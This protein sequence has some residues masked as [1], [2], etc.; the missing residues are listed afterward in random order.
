MRRRTVLMGLFALLLTLGATAVSACGTD[1]RASAALIER[2]LQRPVQSADITFDLTV[3]AE[4]APGLEEPL[5][6]RVTG[7]YRAGG[8]RR[9]PSFD[10]DVAFSGAGQN[11][12]AGLV[13]TGEN[14][15]VTFLGNAY[16]VGEREVARKN[17]ELARAGRD[18]PRGSL[19]DLGIDPRDWVVGA[20][21][22]GGEKVAGVD[23]THLSGRIDVARM[24]ADLGQVKRGASGR[25]H[26]RLSEAERRALAAAVEE[27]RFDAWVARGDETI[28]RLD[29]EVEL[30]APEDRRES[31]R[32]GRGPLGALAAAERAR[33]EFSLELTDVGGDQRI[34]APANPRPLSELGRALEGMGRE[35]A[36][37]GMK[38]AMGPASASLTG[39]TGR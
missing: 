18:R 20:Q 14:A 33:I 28:R 17:R 16:E 39:H 30:R 38:G 1:E 35:G 22:E 13:S 34:Q 29:G 31:P 12:S 25:G 27:N 3:D 36:M 23:S 11:V 2:A 7:P 24:L 5:R 10:W 9:L 4:G 15:F 37:G 8:G 32:S 19:E 6:L 21:D 26:H